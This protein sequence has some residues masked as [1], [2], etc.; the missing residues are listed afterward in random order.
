MKRVY[1]P[2][3]HKNQT[4]ARQPSVLSIAMIL[5]TENIVI[6]KRS[7]AMQMTLAATMY[8][9]FMDASVQ[10]NI[11]KQREIVKKEKILALASYV[12]IL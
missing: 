4:E 11:V 7:Y 3:H 1:E 2:C 10:G 6:C 8:L 5:L 12:S 9:Q